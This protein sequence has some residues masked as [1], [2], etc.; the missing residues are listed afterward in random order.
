MSKIQLNS[1]SMAGQLI[2][3]QFEANLNKDAVQPRRVDES[4]F[5][6]INSIMNGKSKFTSVDAAVRDMQDR[7]GLTAYLKKSESQEEVKKIAATD[8]YGDFSDEEVSQN[9]LDNGFEEE[10][11]ESKADPTK[12]SLEFTP[13]EKA[14]TQEHIKHEKDQSFQD[15]LNAAELFEDEKSILNA[16]KLWELKRQSRV[17]THGLFEFA[18]GFATGSGLSE[19][20][21]HS[22]LEKILDF[23]KTRMS[24]VSDWSRAHKRNQE[25]GVKDKYKFLGE[26]TLKE[27]ETKEV[28]NK[29][30]EE[31]RNRLIHQQ[32]QDSQVNLRD[33]MKD[34]SVED[35]LKDKKFPSRNR[36]T[37]AERDAKV[38]KAQVKYPSVIEKCPQV[39]N[40][41]ENVIKSGSGYSSIPA[42]IARVMSI[43]KNDIAE[44]WGDDDLKRL[45][46][47]LNLEEKSKK[48]EVSQT[49]SNLG[50][51]DPD[52]KIDDSNISVLQNLEPK[53]F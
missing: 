46:A 30:N 16:I 31:E 45:V 26:Q 40:T 1:K 44:G 3:D 25:L 35:L 13:G 52:T 18:D 22:Q 8:P 4:I 36:P 7:S 23:K 10:T 51:N 39:L 19:S 29:K 21:I 42:I 37:H 14:S 48:Q 5:N 6:Q 43:H 33:K 50:S 2:A 38:S 27:D 20:E 53:K 49:Y 12:E 15:G 11:F 34:S 32:K 28:L 17:P 24:K 9:L 41:L 47:K